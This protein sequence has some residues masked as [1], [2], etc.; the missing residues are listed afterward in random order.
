MKTKC[1]LMYQN[2]S[3]KTPCDWKQFNRTAQLVNINNTFIGLQLFFL[4]LSIYSASVYIHVLLVDIA[5]SDRCTSK[6]FIFNI[7]DYFVKF[8]Y[9]WLWHQICFQQ[10]M[11]KNF[12][13]P[14]LT[15]VERGNNLWV[16]MLQILT[17]MEST[18]TLSLVA[19]EHE[20]AD[21]KSKTCTPHT[22]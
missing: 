11:I 20:T 21:G 16:S 7:N 3:L 1:F 4:K 22:S 15:F 17:C 19:Q 6:Q 9:T 14:Q 12:K 2:I 5:V 8:I 10:S 13:Q 18:A